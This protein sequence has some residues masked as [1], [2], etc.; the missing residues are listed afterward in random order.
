MLLLVFGSGAVSLWASRNQA[1]ALGHMQEASAL[2][3]NHMNADMMHD[4]VRADV[5][6]ILAAG[7]GSGTDLAEGQKDLAEHLAAL[8]KSIKTDEAY[9]N[10]VAVHDAAVA[11]QPAVE[12]YIA[13]A[14]EIAGKA[15]DNRAAALAI[16][17]Q[18]IGEF[19][20]LE[21]AM[22]KVSDVIENHTDEVRAS[23]ES[24]S[25]TAIVLILLGMLASAAVVGAIGVA[26]R[27]FLVAP[28]IGLVAV[29][30]RMTSGDLAAE[31]PCAARGDELGQ[32]AQATLALRDQLAGAEREKAA[33]T[34]LIVE[35]IGA[36]LDALAKGDLTRRIDAEL[37]GP[38]AKLKAD[39]NGAMD[40]VSQTLVAVTHATGQIRTGSG[41][42]SQAS[43]DLSRRTEQQAASLEETAAA[44]SEIT[45]TVRETASAATRANSAVLEARGE[46][47]EGGRVVHEAVAAMGGIE[48]SAHE[49]SDIISVID[50]I[51]FQTNLLALNAGVEAARAGDAGK[52]FAVVA[53][54]VRALAQ[55]SAEAAKDVKTRI[56]VSSEQV[57]AGVALV[58]KTGKALER[59]IARIGE[60]SVLVSTIATSAEQQASGLQQVNTAVAEMDNVTQQNAAMVEQATA[61]ARSLA[62]EADDLARQV[63]RF[64][65]GQDE[66][67]ANPVHRLQNRAR[68]ALPAARPA[69][70]VK[71]NLAVQ[72]DDWSEF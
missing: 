2:L 55:R 30:K 10:S 26:C 64:R 16:L 58:D 68:A 4:A 36:G 33:Q 11:V 15:T 8:E 53:S 42:I 69:P 43:D 34:A 28:L 66:I 56:T 17:P 24:I 13:A 44:M 60:I 41:E 49:I 31:V 32:L 46:A 65:T 29:L 21:G 48:R 23:A 39:F 6:S 62:A 72:E 40:S 12:G 63:A 1:S 37:T 38:F 47:E 19:H 20:Q 59:I 45:G 51:A 71:G 9:Q 50:G 70:A 14:R 27:R 7:P 61:A 57:E 25:G 54:E 18:F 5:L 3:R 22:D 67:N 52:G 35:N